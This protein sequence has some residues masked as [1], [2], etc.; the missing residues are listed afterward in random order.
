MSK[1]ATPQR[2]GENDTPGGW[3]YP[4]PRLEWEMWPER[5]RVFRALVPELT[6]AAPRS[7]A[8]P[9]I[10]VAGAGYGFLLW[11]LWDAGFSAWGI[12]GQWAVGKSKGGGQIIPK[13]PNINDHMF[14]GDCTNLASVRNV[15][16]QAGIGGQQKF[17]AVITEDL[18]T[19][20]DSGAEVQT[21]LTTLRDVAPNVRSRVVHFISMYDE[22]QPWSPRLTTEE[23]AE[24]YYAGEAEWITLIG[25]NAERIVN[26]QNNHATVR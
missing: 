7:D 13:L 6:P 17:A 8:G 25:N 9:K 26:I 23:R 21:M 24:G 15:R 3:Y 16:S 12:D 10:L 14:S 11:Y 19:A 22:T 20:A 1:F 5:V 2:F 4:E 18:L